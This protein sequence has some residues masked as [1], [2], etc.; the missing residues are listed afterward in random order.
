MNIKTL[1]QAKVDAEKFIERC[2]DIESSISESNSNDGDYLGKKRYESYDEAAE[3][4]FMYGSPET[5]ALKRQSM[6]LTRSL[7]KLRK[8]F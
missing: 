3:N 6:E 2:E 8:P 7:S 4:Y 5:S 1:K